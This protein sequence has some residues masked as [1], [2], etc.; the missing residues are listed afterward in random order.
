[1]WQCPHPLKS[2]SALVNTGPTLISL[3]LCIRLVGR[4]RCPLCIPSQQ[5]TA[6]PQTKCGSEIHRVEGS[7][8][9]LHIPASLCLQLSP[10]LSLTSTSFLMLT[11]SSATSADALRRS[12]HWQR[13]NSRHM[14]CGRQRDPLLFASSCTL[15]VQK[16]ARV[17]RAFIPELPEFAK[18]APRHEPPPSLLLSGPFA[19]GDML[20]AKHGVSKG[21]GSVMCSG[22][23]Q[24]GNLLVCHT[25]R[26]NGLALPDDFQWQ[27]AA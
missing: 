16:R 25:C 11:L 2:I 19:S 27:G 5:R 4:L 3:C 6:P 9:T 22:E 15:P 18:R 13:W 26:V 23:R 1:M 12:S 14:P 8:P 10:K 24:N 7:G 21:L 17:A 20:P